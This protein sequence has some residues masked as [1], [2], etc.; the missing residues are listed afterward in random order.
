MLNKI[1]IYYHSNSLV[2]KMNS[3]IKMLCVILF[4][5]MI[6]F[7]NNLK[8]N[9]VI[10][11]LATLMVLN[12]K[13]PVRIYFK[14]ILSIKW[15]L[16]FIIIINFI[17]KL[18]LEFN[19]MIIVRIIYIIIYMSILFFTTPFLEI[20]SGFEVLFYPLKLFC[21]PVDKMALFKVTKS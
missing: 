10:F 21:L 2:H 11:I 20:I 17:L 12:T 4:I 7:A 8:T 15:L 18:P 3:F 5:I 6:F 13:V 9:V 19:V 1:G 14:M 16:L